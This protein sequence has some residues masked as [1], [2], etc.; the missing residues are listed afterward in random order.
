MDRYSVVMYPFGAF[1]PRG[2]ETLD[3]GRAVPYRG[4]PAPDRYGR[5]RSAFIAGDPQ[6]REIL[7]GSQASLDAYGK[8]TTRSTASADGGRAIAP[9]SLAAAPSSRE[10]VN[11]YLPPPP[12]ADATFRKVP[13]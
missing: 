12:S 3:R 1:Q 13:E 5:A 11:R 7:N 10:I 8:T 6:T 4:G 2:R 9:R